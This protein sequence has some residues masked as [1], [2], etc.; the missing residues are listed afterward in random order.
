MKTSPLTSLVARYRLGEGQRGQLEAVLERLEQDPG[1][2]TTVR[3]PD[4]AADVHLADSLSALELPGVAD[5]RSIADLGAGAGFPGL[6][7]AVA[8]PQAKVWLLESQQRK[9]AFLKRL[10]AAAQAANVRVACT[11]SE[12]WREGFGAQEL[13]TARALAPQSV[14]LEYAAPLL[15]VGGTLLDWRGRRDPGEERAAAC[16]A[17]QLGLELV[18][19]HRTEPYPGAHDHHLHRFEKRTPTPPRFPRRPGI[20]RK[21]PLGC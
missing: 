17:E 9:C 5:V 11:R 20:A 13:V 1:A 15:C 12:Q 3:A 10:L 8:L 2:P 4:L 18:E 16:A 7:L 14:V 19:V 6:P 21:R